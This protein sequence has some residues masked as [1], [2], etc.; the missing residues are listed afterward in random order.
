MERAPLVTNPM[1]IPRNAANSALHLTT[2]LLAKACGPVGLLAALAL[3]A[4]PVAL[5]AEPATQPKL[6]AA[7]EPA[8]A[9]GDAAPVDPTVAVD[10]EG[11]PIRGA[12]TQE[13]AEAS[14][15]EL[16]RSIRVFQQR[17]LLKAL[18]LEVLAGGNMTF[19]DA[20]VKHYAADASLLFHI[21]EKLAIGATA[22]K[23]WGSETSAFTS[24]ESN[25]GLFPEKSALQ[26]GGHLEVQW[27]PLIGK[28]A[29]FGAGPMQMDGYLLAGGGAAR[30]TRGEDLKP[31]GTA[32]IG[33][34]LHTLRWLTVSIEAR[35]LILSETFQTGSRL[36]QHWSGG[37]RLGFWIPPTFQYRYER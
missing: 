18:R 27:S 12:M 1:H 5:A 13:Q 2:R 33:V 15:A 17:Y 36:L 35:D 8:P 34:R 31:Y 9:G 21:N 25:F 7:A 22:M 23:W 32:G 20:W 14:E 19:G 10:A 24:V 37:I 28:F 30:T 6:A 4:C 29:L 26:A 16:Q 3:S 11:R